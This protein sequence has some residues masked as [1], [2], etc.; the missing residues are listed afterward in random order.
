MHISF[1]WSFAILLG[2]GLCSPAGFGQEKE[3][4]AKTP[5][6]ETSD[7]LLGG[8]AMQMV[9]YWHLP[10]LTS[11]GR[12]K[13]GDL[14]AALL[15]RYKSFPDDLM[16]ALGNRGSVDHE[17]AVRFLAFYA[18]LARGH[19]A[20]LLEKDLSFA[21]DV[22]LAPHTG[23]IRKGLAAGL[24]AKASKA[25]LMAALALLC[26]DESHAQANA[27]L[28][29]SAACADAELLTETSWVIGV[30]RLTSPQAMAYLGRLLKHRDPKVR[31]SAAGAAITMGPS[32]GDLAPALVA[33]LETGENA[34]GTYC[35]PFAIAFPQ[36]GNLALMALVSLKE[37]AKPARPAILGRFVKANDED[38]VAMLACLASIGHHNDACLAVVRKSLKNGKSKL[39]LAAACTLLHLAPG[40]HE[41][42]E[43]LKKALADEATKNLAMETCQR[44]GPPSREIAAS[45]LPMLD[46]S[47]EDVR[48]NATL[49]LARIGLHAVEAV[50][51]IEKLLATEEDHR[52]HTF[53]STRRA[54]YALAQIRGKEAAAAL[55]RVADSRASGA[56]YAMMYLPE[57]G[58]DLPP[59]SLA[60]LVRAIE[61]DDRPKDMAAIALSNLGERARPVRR[62][63][64]RLLEVPEA[65]WILDTALRCIPVDRR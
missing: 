61:S 37:H 2:I 7:S 31:E 60:I 22:A 16:K 55:L 26:L 36:S 28:Q 1:F 51:R 53:Q 46:D 8:C 54:A 23:K 5:F 32:A 27:V 6:Q 17:T 38:Q 48:I 65:G 25:R 58:D 56:R 52:T 14:D 34:R 11:W 43:L 49:A 21:V 18:G 15:K 20:Q 64:E 50:P 62:D 45:L 9:E 12:L 13:G 42:T 10:H 19:A 3:E 24:Q 35:Y 39:K 59:M 30:A 33:F 4:P 29:A 41:A 44:F 47:T 40:D 57:L 63:L